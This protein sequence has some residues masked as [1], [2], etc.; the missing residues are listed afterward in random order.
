MTRATLNKSY[1]ALFILV[2]LTVGACKDDQKE[3]PSQSS[4][5][6]NGIYDSPS[7]NYQEI[8]TMNL[9]DTEV[10]RED[11]KEETLLQDSVVVALSRQVLLAFKQDNARYLLNF[12][13]PTIG[14]RFSPY[15]Y[16]DTLRDVKVDPPAFERLTQDPSKKILWGNYDGSGEPIEL[17]FTAYTKK[18]IYDVDF[19]NA[20]KVSLNSFIGQG[21]SLNNL[22]QVYA[23]ADFVEYHFSGFDKKYEGMDWRSLRIVFKK[24]NNKYYLLG[25]VHDQWTS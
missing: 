1:W 17:T 10:I 24:I 13:H 22:Q 11:T 3:V 19:M 15:G 12:I 18:F 23:G 6:S 8:D 21:N 20:E 7:Q 25:I 2:Q 14:L 4:T 16:V 9:I 5:G